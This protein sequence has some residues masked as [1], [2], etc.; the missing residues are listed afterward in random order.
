M[1]QKRAT[2]L[3]VED[4]PDILQLLRDELQDE[5]FDIMEARD[6]A[7]ALQLIATMEPPDLVLL[8]LLLPVMDGWQFLKALTDRGLI[9]QIPVIAVSAVAYRGAPGAVAA[10]PKPINIAGL[11]VIISEVRSRGHD[12]AVG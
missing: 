6:G 12:V 9:G 5:G 10:V 3:I 2:I 7:Q 4:D 11:M 8:D 1:E